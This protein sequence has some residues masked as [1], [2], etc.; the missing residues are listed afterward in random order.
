MIVTA[1][2]AHASRLVAESAVIVTVAATG[3]DSFRPLGWVAVTV[4][5]IE[6]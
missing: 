3:A 4:T 5:W 2:G 6:A 1:A